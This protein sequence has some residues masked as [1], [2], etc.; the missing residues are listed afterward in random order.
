MRS[1]GGGAVPI[2]G[3]DAV[4]VIGYHLC[5]TT[6]SKL[7]HD[8][9]VAELPSFGN[10]NAPTASTAGRGVEIGSGLAAILRT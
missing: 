8:S 2:Q 6:R 5:V 4:R 1:P 7:K 3:R 9:R 10:P